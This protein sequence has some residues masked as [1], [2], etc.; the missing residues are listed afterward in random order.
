MTFI[1]PLMT[2]QELFQSQNAQNA[3]PAGQAPAQ[4]AKA[5]VSQ[6]YQALTGDTF[7][8]SKLPASAGSAT[9]QVAFAET[10]QVQYQVSP[11]H[12]T[13]AFAPAYAITAYHE[14]GV[15]RTEKDP[16]A[17][18]AITTPSKRQDLGGKT[19]GTYQFE[20]YIYKNGDRHSQSRVENSTLMR[21]L[22]S[23]GNPF[24]EALLKVARQEGLA[25]SAFDKAWKELAQNQNKAFGLAQQTFFEHEAR[26][27]VDAF[28]DR[29]G[30]QGAARQSPELVDLVMGT[31][32]QFGG[33][34][35]KMAD[36]LQAKQAEADRS[37]SA[38]EVGMT[39]SD[40][41]LSRVTSLFKSSPGAW[42]GVRARF[43]AER[44]VFS[45]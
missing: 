39:L 12:R 19:Y 11:H 28:F 26:Q 23:P 44:K 15:Y 37:F 30:I 43:Q 10:P 38:R 8:A 3:S 40:Y 27:K 22:K 34:A 29:A 16:Y 25:S 14:S 9:S 36:H 21:F 5:A 20:S 18:G 45:S 1:R 33:L 13:D 17:V 32:N 31:L 35:N 24:G 4:P 2:P 42:A 7:S 6:L 41:K